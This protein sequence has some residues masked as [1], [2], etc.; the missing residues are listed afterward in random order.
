MDK[1]I[2]LIQKTPMAQKIAL[3][4]FLIVGMGAGYY[5]LVHTDLEKDIKKLDR[6]LAT[7]ETELQEKQEI[8]G[9]LS[10][11][12]KRV[13]FLQQK[14]EEKK[15]NLPD[16]ANLDP[17][18]GGLVVFTAK[19]PADWDFVQYN[20]DTERVRKELLAP[21]GYANVTIPYRMNRAVIFDSALFHQTDTFRFRPGYKNRRINLTLLYGTMQTAS[22]PSADTTSLPLNEKKAAM[23]DE[24]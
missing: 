19:P 20:T 7:L 22:G 1:V 9:N 21:T 10:K 23:K 13:E 6:Q 14:L 12:R 17:T 11:F 8:A 16:D 2:A 24:L 5:F 15:K 18:S 4:G 3:L